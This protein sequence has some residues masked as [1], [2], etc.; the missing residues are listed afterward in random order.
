MGCGPQKKSQP[1]E[2]KESPVGILKVAILG[3]L[4]HQNDKVANPNIKIRVSNQHFETKELPPIVKDKVAGETFSYVINSF[5]K[6]HGRSIE[7]GYF[8]GDT[9]ISFGAVDANPAIEKKGPQESRCILHQD[10]EKEHGYVLL[11]ATF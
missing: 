10:K 2:R 1:L 11:R 7:V 4:I 3:V 9:L 8:S 5:Y 6:A